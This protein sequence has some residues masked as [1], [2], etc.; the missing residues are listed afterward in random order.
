VI[1]KL[2]IVPAPRAISHHA[3]VAR[4]LGIDIITGQYPEGAKL[5]GDAELI[6]LF[7][8]SRPVLREGVKT[9]VA[10]G[11][12]STKAKVGTVVRERSAW[13]MFDADVLAWHLVG[14][15]DSSLLFDLGEIR[16]AV[17]P[18]SAALAARQRNNA[19]IAEMRSSIEQ[20]RRERSSS[21]GFAEGDLRL[22]IAIAEASNNLF[23]RSMG[24][25][26]QAAL[27]ASFLISAPVSERERDVT[28][29]A[30]VRIVDAIENRN[31]QVASAE[32]ANVIVNGINRLQG[33][34]ATPRGKRRTVGRLNGVR[35]RVQRA[36]QT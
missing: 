27:R 4:I 32:M 33:S 28:M 18:R 30:H 2:V 8:V 7:G 23:M 31:P 16:L 34:I 10:K 20:M 26:I 17:E 25:V 21:A 29:E 6:R 11:L 24:G 12:L 19:H 14:R 1:S 5:P 35:K 9:L 15:I 3:E 22:H 13:N 36:N